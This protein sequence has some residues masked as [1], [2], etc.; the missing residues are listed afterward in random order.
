M[1]NN[2]THFKH[3]YEN[4]L[5][6]TISSSNSCT[7]LYNIFKQCLFVVLQTGLI[8]LSSFIQMHFRDGEILAVSTM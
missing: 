6:R 4:D 3:F 2:F 5:L 1:I 7:V 8:S